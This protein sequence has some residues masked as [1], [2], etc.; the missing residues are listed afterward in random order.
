MKTEF[1]DKKYDMIMIKM[2]CWQQF[3]YSTIA[4]VDLMKS[5]K[6]CTFLLTSVVGGNT[7]YNDFACFKFCGCSVASMST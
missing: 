5:K 6:C 1:C 7:F 3:V 4:K 2:I